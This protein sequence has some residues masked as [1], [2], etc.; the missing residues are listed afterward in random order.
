VLPRDGIGAEGERREEIHQGRKGGGRGVLGRYAQTPTEKTRTA[1]D[2]E[3]FV[4]ASNDEPHGVRHTREGQATE[5][6]R[7]W[8]QGGRREWRRHVHGA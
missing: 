8:V 4:Q 6:K 2:E 3:I 7:R 5:E 1:A